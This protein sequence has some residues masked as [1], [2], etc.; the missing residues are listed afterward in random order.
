MLLKSISLPF[1]YIHLI[2]PNLFSSDSIEMK[3]HSISRVR[4][5]I[6][7]VYNALETV[8]KISLL[9]DDED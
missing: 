6:M 8:Y 9:G 2:S 5:K 4:D 7:Y 3:Y 1:N